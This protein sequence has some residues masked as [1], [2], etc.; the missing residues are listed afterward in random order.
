MTTPV[1]PMATPL[2]MKA[3]NM[4]NSSIAVSRSKVLVLG[5][6]SCTSGV[7]VSQCCMYCPSA[8]FHCRQSN[9]RHSRPTSLKI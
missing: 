3:R 1:H 9:V 4:Q 6:Y 7:S 8:Y 2:L 5:H